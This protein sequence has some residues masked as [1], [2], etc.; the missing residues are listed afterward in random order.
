[1]IQFFAPLNRNKTYMVVQF[2]LFFLIFN[3]LLS[4]FNCRQ[5]MSRS[6]RF[7]L[8]E[9]TEKTLKNLPEKLYIDAF[10]SSS[11]PSEYK[12]RI[13][14]LKELLR[15]IAAKNTSMVT[16][17]FY[18]PDS[19]E[20]HKKKAEQFGI[21]PLTI[22][23]VER[24][25]AQVKNAAY[26]GLNLKIGAKSETMPVV[27]EAERV[28]YQILSTLRKMLKKTS[29]SGVGLVKAGGTMT[30]PYRPGPQT[31]KNTIGLFVRQAFEPEYGTLTEV[32]INED[33]VPED[34]NTLILSGDPEL[35]DKGKFHLDQFIVKGGSLIVMVKSMDFTLQKQNRQMSMF[36]GGN[37]NG[38]ASPAKHIKDLNQF[39]S[40]YGFQIK[41]NM[42]LEK[43]NSMPIGPL[44]QMQPGVIGRY[45]YPVWI[46]AYKEDGGLN[47]ESLYTRNTEGIL[48]PWASEIEFIKDR[49]KEAKTKVLVQSTVSADVRKEF[50][51]LSEEQLIKQEIKPGG[52]RLPLVGLLEGAF[53]S[54]FS[55][56]KLPEGITEANFVNKTPAKRKARILVIGTPYLIADILAMNR[57]TGEVFQSSNIPF[58]LNLLDT[59]SGDTDL[60]AARSKQSAI[61]NL[62][63][64]D[65]NVERIASFIN[66]GLFPLIL[67]IYA[68]QRLKKRN[69]AV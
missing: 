37:R 27:I 12:A 25:S 58:F 16:L 24:G 62:K 5:D 36:G 65:K 48:L 1:M 10:Y 39:F 34:V 68:F 63:P 61:L 7:E 49:Q 17:R 6:H 28:E 8:T 52:K 11:I 46:I 32:N 69:R 18:D 54:T 51:I 42:V 66:V 57:D 20:E 9:S 29:G 2:I 31:G 21:R 35:N 40:G 60:L 45:H 56:D 47:Q 19:N 67:V 26:F 41:Q 50:V 43:D 53:T 33:S 23:K 15:E 55:P 59:I 44:V 13:T 38:I 30:A 4:G 64:V 14:L 22:Q 3:Y